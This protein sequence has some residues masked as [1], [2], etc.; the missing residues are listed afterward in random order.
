MEDFNVTQATAK[1]VEV[2]EFEGKTVVVLDQTCFYPKGGGQDFDL[3]TISSGETSFTVESVFFVDG[4]VKHIGAF[5]GASLNVGDEVS[6]QV[7]QERRLLNTKLHSAGHVVDMAVRSLGWDWI[8]GKGAH[9]PHMSF[10]EYS[11]VLDPEAKEQ[12]KQELQATVSQLIAKGSNNTIAFMSPEEMAEHGTVL[13]EHLPKGK[14]TRAVL[15]DD[16]AVPCGGTH[17]KNINDI[18][19]IIVTKIKNKDGNI[20]VSYSL[21]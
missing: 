4:E 10:V 19:E 3:G 9:Y 21:G 7:D 6:C 15:Y 8:P 16:F 13:P 2:A 14:P 1:V 11:G 17:V 18:G 12:Q 20:R 5:T